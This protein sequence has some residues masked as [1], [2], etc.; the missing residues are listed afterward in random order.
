VQQE[1]RTEMWKGKI[2]AARILYE[3]GHS[4]TAASITI[5]LE[6]KKSGFL[7]MLS[8]MFYS[9]SYLEKKHLVRLAQY[10]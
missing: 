6:T 10:T 3:H 7:H 9:T 2:G 5:I 4:Q 8:V 1:I